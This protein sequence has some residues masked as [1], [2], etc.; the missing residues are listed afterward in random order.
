MRADRLIVAV[1]AMGAVM[2]WIADTK[3]PAATPTPPASNEITLSDAQRLEVGDFIRRQ[4]F[5]CPAAKM[6]FG[7]GP[8]AY[9][10]VVKVLCGPP[11]RDGV[12]SKLAFRV[13]FGA[14]DTVM[15][16]PW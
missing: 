6:F 15:V 9:G 4:G 2:W 1:A 10:D 16:R 13:T 3:K 14:N 11:D 7:K 12:Y 5:N 8:D